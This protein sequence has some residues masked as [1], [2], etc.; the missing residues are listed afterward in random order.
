MECGG[1]RDGRRGSGM[2]LPAE[3]QCEIV[4]HLGADASVAEWRKFEQY[5]ARWSFSFEGLLVVWL[6]ERRAGSIFWQFVDHPDD[7]KFVAKHVAGAYG[8]TI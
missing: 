6:R 8:S 1:V 4:R 3:L 7:V 2:C 5:C